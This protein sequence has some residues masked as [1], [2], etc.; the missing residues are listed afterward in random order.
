MAASK[1]R[2]LRQSVTIKAT[3]NDVYDTLV[4]ARR[5]AEFTGAAARLE[6]KVGG[7]FEHYDGSLSGVVVDL[8]PGRRIVL[9]W[10]SSGWPERHYSIAEFDLKPVAGGTKLVFSQ[11]GIPESDFEDIADGWKTYYWQPLK[12]Y[13]E[14]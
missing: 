5:H 1:V 9:A 8:D 3:P 4:R 11:Y 13:L 2:N 12:E 14:T 10:R 7:R 6:A